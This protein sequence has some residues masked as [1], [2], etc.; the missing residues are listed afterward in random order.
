ML[1]SLLSKNH[2]KI[3]SLYTHYTIRTPVILVNVP[4]LTFI[5]R[6]IK[7]ILY[8]GN[9]KSLVARICLSKTVTSRFIWKNESS[10]TYPNT[11]LYANSPDPRLCHSLDSLFII[12]F[13]S[14]TTFSS[15]FC[16]IFKLAFYVLPSD[17]T[18][19][20]FIFW[21]NISS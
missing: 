6:K 15:W 11:G 2:S 3:I 4:L 16:M 20:I 9:E 14:F 13:S 19:K 12:F 18:Q 1:I 17:S 8:C 10:L 21:H 7:S 5:I